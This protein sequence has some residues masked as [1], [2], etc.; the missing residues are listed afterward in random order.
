[1]PFCSSDEPNERLRAGE[2][3]KFPRPTCVPGSRDGF[4]DGSG[5]CLSTEHADLP[6][7]RPERFA[8]HLTELP[9]FPVRRCPAIIYFRNGNTDKYT[10]TSFTAR[11]WKGF[12]FFVFTD[13]EIRTVHT[14]TLGR[15]RG[16]GF[17]G[18]TWRFPNK[19]PSGRTSF[20]PKYLCVYTTEKIV[21]ITN[22]YLLRNIQK[23]TM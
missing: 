5:L 3:T 13:I 18:R 12:F 14:R 22:I 20:V 23:T 1:M 8:R 10:G 9:R 6:G 15:P 11:I 2:F 19:N 21:F 7:G 16:C 4:P 17:Q